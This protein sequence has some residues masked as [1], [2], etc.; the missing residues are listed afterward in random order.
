[1]PVAVEG[2]ANRP[3][4]NAADTRF[5]EALAR[6]SCAILADAASET[7]NAPAI[8]ELRRAVTLDPDGEVLYLQLGALLIK[9]EQFEE[10]AALL[11]RGVG[12][13]PDNADMRLLLAVSCHAAG[14]LDDAERA[15]RRAI[16]LA[17]DR[18]EA[19]IKLAALHLTRNNNAA[20]FKVLDAG[21][22]QAAEP[23]QILLFYDYL[24]KLY[25]V[26]KKLPLAIGCYERIR[27]QQPDNLTVQEQLARCYVAAGERQKAIVALRELA[28]K[29]PDKKVWHYY[30]GE[31]Y[32]DMGDTDRAV[33]EFQQSLQTV[34]PTPEP[35]VRLAS[36]Y[37]RKD[38]AKAAQTLRSA[39]QA[40]PDDPL[41]QTFLGLV[42]SY[43]GSFKDAIVAFERAERIVTESADKKYVLN[44][45]FYYW[46][47]SACEQDGQFDR[48]EVLLEKCIQLYP[49]THEPYNYL[50]YMWAEKGIKLD[51]ALEYVTRALVLLPDEP[52]Y[53]DTL[54]WVYYKKGDYPK[55][56][57]QMRKAVAAVPDDA[58][59]LDHLGDVLK[60]MGRKDEAVTQWKK[61][62][63]LEPES[64]AVRRKLKENGVEP[65]P[66]R[67]K[68]KAPPEVSE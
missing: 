39:V 65:A 29:Q 8:V 31:L 27:K 14:K 11:K 15:Y 1:M 13:F 48:G 36:L 51:K 22:K 9:D 17:P 54:G 30:L 63:E 64:E 38:R 21:V 56:L 33:A 34:P 19:Y 6:Y 55:A 23:L 4:L 49:Q 50:A 7:N 5:S 59:L 35:F 44:P 47:G 41:I 37:L 52:A 57:E 60:A 46:Y 32:E 28:E 12:Y 24:A 62:L 2:E 42:L 43:G 20:A 68:Q 45:M 66:L 10:A 3:P 25:I 61:S 53:I 58:T 40:M 18:G 67:P 26:D 16:K